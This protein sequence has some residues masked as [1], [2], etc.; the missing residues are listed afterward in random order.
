MNLKTLAV[1][2]G[3]LKM[4]E[5]RL[6]L[7]G[8][9][10]GVLLLGYLLLI[11]PPMLDGEAKRRLLAQHR[12]ELVTLE[13]QLAGLRAQAANPDARLRQDLA[14]RKKQLESAEND[15][16][17]LSESLVAPAQ[18]PHLLQSLLSKHK[19]LT[20]VRLNTLPVSALLKPASASQPARGAAES[21]AASLGIYRHGI[22][23]T[24][25]GSYAD[26]TAYADELRR[27]TPRLLWSAMDLK[28]V[29]Y[30]R[31]EM[32]FTLY[33]LSLDLPWLAV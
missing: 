7:I 13:E 17:P 32:T 12:G 31:S 26:L 3:K 1:R 33:T 16:K 8:A 18:M 15:L 19:N 29:E 11:E 30:P 23:I 25:A 9:V 6:I 4:N 27:V 28:V 2:F 24:V 20:L 5:R 10:T 14:S 21:S 22:E